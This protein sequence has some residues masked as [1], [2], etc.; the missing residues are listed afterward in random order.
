ME[1]FKGLYHQNLPSIKA[2]EGLT[3]ILN[4][5]RNSKL[6]PGL[7]MKKGQVVIIQVIHNLSSLSNP[8]TLTIVTLQKQRKKINHQEGMKEKVP[9]PNL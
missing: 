7:G 4:Q 9:E 2:S 5:E 6:K 1:K 3:S 8:Q